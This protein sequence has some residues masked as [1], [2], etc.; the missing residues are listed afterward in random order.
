MSI[1]HFA[2][3][4]C[5]TLKENTRREMVSR[6][7]RHLS[8]LLVTVIV[9]SWFVLPESL[10]PFVTSGV[11]TVEAQLT[12]TL[13]RTKLEYSSP[14]T[15]DFNFRVSSD[16]TNPTAII[17]QWTDVKD[18]TVT[19]VDTSYQPKNTRARVDKVYAYKIEYID[20]A[21]T[22]NPDGAMNFRSCGA[23]SDWKSLANNYPVSVPG[24]NDVKLT[25]SNGRANIPTNPVYFRLSAA[26]GP[27]AF[28]KTD[29]ITLACT[30]TQYTHSK[31]SASSTIS[32]A[33]ANTTANNTS[34]GTVPTLNNSCSTGFNAANEATSNLFNKNIQ[35]TTSL[36]SYQSICFIFDGEYLVHKFRYDTATTKNII[37]EQ[38]YKPDSSIKVYGGCRSKDTVCN[39]I[40]EAFNYFSYLDKVDESTQVTINNGSAGTGAPGVTDSYKD[41]RKASTEVKLYR[42][43]PA[44]QV[45][46]GVANPNFNAYILAYGKKIVYGFF[47]EQNID[48]FS[49]TEAKRIEDRK[50]DMA[51]GD[52]GLDFLK[53]PSSNLEQFAN[54][55][56]EKNRPHSHYIAAVNKIAP[57][58]IN[59][60]T[61]DFLAGL[62]DQEKSIKARANAAEL[63]GDV[64]N[65]IHNSLTGTGTE[66]TTPENFTLIDGDIDL[67]DD[68]NATDKT[69]P[70]ISP[71]VKIG[72]A[73]TGLPSQLIYKLR[74]ALRSSYDFQYS[75]NNY[76]I[77]ELD[78]RTPD[79]VKKILQDRGLNKDNHFFAID[80]AGNIAI[81][82]E[83]K[84]DNGGIFGGGKDRLDK[85][86]AVG[87]FD[88]GFTGYSVSKNVAGKPLNINLEQY[89]S[90]ITKRAYNNPAV[91]KINNADC[92]G[93]PTVNYPD[94]NTGYEDTSVVDKFKYGM[95]VDI[96]RK[97]IHINTPG[98]ASPGWLGKWGVTDVK[99]DR[100]VGDECASSLAGAEGF[101]KM[102]GSA[103]CW[104]LS[105]LIGGSIWLAGF[106]VDFMLKA[107]DVQ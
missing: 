68:P 100:I 89:R 9:T 98:E 81:I 65:S 106:S 23:T 33:T 15:V 19:N 71:I 53:F 2:A 24:T 42:F 54:Y 55:T 5:Y 102:I 80:V 93:S 88:G 27:N 103:V 32:N 51:N 12:P 63:F 48:R 8:L 67:I 56:P 45:P 62:S 94:V 70:E 38:R 66:T 52:A 1:L 92:Q 59:G 46:L 44:L 49:M 75:Q 35:N 78:E 50:K 6:L 4:T 31:G 37:L 76:F 28:N 18:T 90:I 34:S 57:Y 7:K 16:S 25:L 13:S 43:D 60:A 105:Y 79:S 101:A 20:A 36:P 72:N 58:C 10:Q 69:N 39:N 47:L 86:L 96:Y 107:V 21:Q 30:A 40:P 97:C 22:G 17:F 84:S 87:K 64:T 61:C 82:I 73:N 14:Y 77:F 91:P 74:Y 85:Y 3:R 26:F 83:D 41:T 95:P 29:F 11:E 104:M 99:I